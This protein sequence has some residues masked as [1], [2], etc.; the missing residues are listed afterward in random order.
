MYRYIY[1]YIY[2][3]LVGYLSMII[4]LS[5]LVEFVSSICCSYMKFGTINSE[6]NF[7]Y[8]VIASLQILGHH[9]VVS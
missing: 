6:Q 1:I 4:L 5:C 2:S 3:L 8:S 7:T 9:K